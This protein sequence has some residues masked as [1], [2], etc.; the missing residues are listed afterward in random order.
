MTKIYTI[1]KATNKITGK[2]YIGFDSRW[3]RRMKTHNRVA[4]RQ[5][6]NT[7]FHNVIRKYGKSCF[8]WEV[9][10]QS[11]DGHHCLNIMEPYFIKEHNSYGEGGYNLTHG[12][13]QV[14]MG[15]KHSHQTRQR[16]SEKLKLKPKEAKNR[17][18]K[19]WLV[20]NPDGITYKITNLF[21]FCKEHHLNQGSMWGVSVGKA[22]RH[23]GWDCVKLA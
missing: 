14:M 19:D 6:E 15:R 3:P 18:A 12:G 20:T 1:Y 8:D 2:C 17:M 11:L 23:K 22:K 9:L 7:Y 5:E 4:Y 21:E 16:L 13:D 10:Y